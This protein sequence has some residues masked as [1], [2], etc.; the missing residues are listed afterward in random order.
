MS[1]KGQKQIQEKLGK[2]SSCYVL[3]T[4]DEPS[5]DGKMQVKMTRKGDPLLLSYLLEKAHTL[6]EQEEEEAQTRVFKLIK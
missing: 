3:I 1:S 5:S 2:D 4:C 6:M